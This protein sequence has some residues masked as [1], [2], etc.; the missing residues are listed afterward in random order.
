MKE[1]VELSMTHNNSSL[2]YMETLMSIA[3]Y[4]G[5]MNVVQFLI[6]KF[7][8][9]R[10]CFV[11]A[12]AALISSY[13]PDL[14][15]IQFFAN[16]PDECQTYQRHVHH[17]NLFNKAAYNGNLEVI[18]WLLV[19]RYEDLENS[20]MF[21]SATTGKQIDVIRY[22]VAEHGEPKDK[23]NTQYICFA[24]YSED[25]F[26]MFKLLYDLG[27]ACSEDIM[28]RA[29]AS[30]S[31]K[32]LKW[33]HENTTFKCTTNTIDLAV[34]KNRLDIVKWLHE[35]RSEGCTV[36]AMN[37]AVNKGNLEFGSMAA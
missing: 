20:T 25:A 26:D 29:A 14:E 37:K 16:I 18:R 33:L 24:L 3:S 17:D 32:V 12:M 28:D 5:R 19:N 15:K 22:L 7:P 1:R 6:D 21:S 2:H 23:D 35:N 10:F 30:G 9:Y 31:M 34:H 4:H 27:C 13:R 36:E 8:T 11:K